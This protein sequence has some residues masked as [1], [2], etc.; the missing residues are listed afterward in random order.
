MIDENDFEE[1]ASQVTIWVAQSLF[2]QWPKGERLS[3]CLVPN[4]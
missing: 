1:E 2:R 3:R 4:L